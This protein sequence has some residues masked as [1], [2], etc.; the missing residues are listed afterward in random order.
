MA[1]LSLALGCAALPGADEDCEAAPSRSA[2]EACVLED[3]ER[4]D[5]I[6]AIRAL[7]PSLTDASLSDRCWLATMRHSE[8]G[9]DTGDCS[10]IESATL[11]G[12]CV[13]AVADRKLDSAPMDDLV[14]TCAEAGVLEATCIDHLVQQGEGRWTE[15]PALDTDLAILLAAHPTLTFDAKTGFRVGYLAWTLGALP[16]EY[17]ACE[18]FPYGDARLACEAAVIDPGLALHAMGGL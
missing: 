14:A 15:L 17:A 11:R 2:Y 6:D 3:T 7:C 5:D 9:D 10:A 4:G 18:V 8:A 13:L 1:L 12:S 16:F